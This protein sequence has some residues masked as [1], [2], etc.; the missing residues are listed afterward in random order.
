MGTFIGE[1]GEV[2]TEGFLK[3]NSNGRKD[4]PDR[5]SVYEKD[6]R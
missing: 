3:R 2:I 5:G 6:K 1:T 4:F